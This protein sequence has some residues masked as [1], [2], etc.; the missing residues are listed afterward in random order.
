M[1]KKSKLEAKKWKFFQE[2]CYEE[3]ERDVAVARMT[4]R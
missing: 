4:M 3:K 1:F 2:V